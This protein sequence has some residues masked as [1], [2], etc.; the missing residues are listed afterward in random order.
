MNTSIPDE[1]TIHAYVDG[2]LDPDASQAVERYLAHHPERAA[3]V[4]A[5]RQ[6]AQRLRAAFGTWPALPDNPALDPARIRVRRR[7]RVRARFATAAM[8]LLCVALGGWGGWQA[9]GLRQAGAEPPMADAVQAY[10]MFAGTP[11]TGADVVARGDG[12]LQAWLDRHFRNAPR[13]PDLHA[14]GYLPVR[15]RLMATDVGPAAMVVYASARGGAISFYLRAP[16]MRGPLPRG[17]RR[18]GSLVAEYGS[19]NGYNYALVSRDDSH[20]LDAVRR[21]LPPSA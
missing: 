20:A 6:D 2:R 21:A 18:D 13:L 12:D 8:L 9:H 5:W 10:R 4:R 19:D 7:R 15:G 1:D 16:S 17:Q 14:A 11:A 3:E